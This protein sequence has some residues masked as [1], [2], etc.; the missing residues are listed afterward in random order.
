M[1]DPFKK[2]TKQDIKAPKALH[3][4]GLTCFAA[5]STLL[6]SLDWLTPLNER[7]W[8]QCGMALLLLI[9]LPST[10]QLARL[11]DNAKR[12]QTERG[13]LLG[14][15]GLIGIAIVLI[16]FALLPSLF[17]AIAVQAH[18]FAQGGKKPWFSAN[19]TLLAG[20]ALGCL[21][22]HPIT[23]THTELTINAASL[24]A[25]ILYFCAYVF[26]I[27][28]QLTYLQ[29]ENNKLIQ[30]HRETSLA[31]YTLSKY[32]PR[33]LWSAVTSGKV[34]GVVTE[35]KLLT[36]FFSDIKDFSRLTEEMEAETLTRLLNHYLT[37]MSRI[38]AK[39]G[40]TIDKFIGDAI[41]VVFG[42]DQSRGPK[43]DALRCVIMALEM[44]KRVQKMMCEWYDQGVSYHL[45]VRMGINTGHCTVGV[46]GTADYQTY[47]VMGSH[48]NLAARLESAAEP[49]E[50][51]VSQYTWGMIKQ[52][53]ICRDKGYIEIKGFSKPVN[54]YQVA[55]LRRNLGGRQTYIEEHAL[56]FSMH[57]ELDKVRN[58]DKEKLLQSLQKASEQLKDTAIS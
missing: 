37:E 58:Y 26:C 38:V 50:I 47:T 54:V 15:C 30:A 20:I 18:S 9:Y 10:Y 24:I 44:R 33:P 2:F 31:S 52:A 29:L 55:D 40:G 32:L 57:L 1:L 12:A 5:I 43:A 4:R 39:H 27:R 23:V 45:Q 16:E 14:D 41:M 13:L 8:L 3:F 11:R 53:V 22:H 25:L 35:G 7:A 17:L 49:G 48:V 42:D 51:L 28:K 34:K 36:I 19:V 46:F 6:T 21:V 56:G